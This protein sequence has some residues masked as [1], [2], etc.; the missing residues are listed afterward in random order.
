[1]ALLSVY[2]RGRCLQQPVLL[3]PAEV[4]AGAA[5]GRDASLVSAIN[6]GD[7]GTLMSASPSR[8]WL[9]PAWPT[10]SSS[11]AGRG[12][13]R[14]VGERGATGVWVMLPLCPAWG[15]PLPALQLP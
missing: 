1:M 8:R 11:P 6:R 2:H 3:G 13:R 7:F 12:S 14:L 5:V 10:A 4:G 15:I 9:R